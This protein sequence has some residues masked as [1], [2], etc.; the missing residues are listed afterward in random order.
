MVGRVMAAAALGVVAAVSVAYGEGVTVQPRFEEGRTLRYELRLEKERDLNM[1]AGEDRLVQEMGLSLETAGS[2]DAGVWTFEG[3]IEWVVI[4]VD[5]ESFRVRVDSRDIVGDSPNLAETTIRGMVE[6]YLES[7]FTA[8][9]SPE[10]EVLE[11]TGMAPVME[12]IG[13]QKGTLAPL[14][15]SDLTPEGLSAALAPVWAGDGSSGR[16]L[17]PGQTFELRR[18]NDLGAGVSI[19][20]TTAYEVTSAGDGRVAYEGTPGVEVVLPPVEMP[21]NIELTEVEG[22]ASVVWDSALGTLRTRDVSLAY[23]MT[24]SVKADESAPAQSSPRSFRSVLELVSVE[25]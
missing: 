15:S 14:A 3:S 23:T 2:D 9:V 1:G 16:T 17:A 8:R 20:V 18:E 5:R 13:E 25:D 12:F 4:D 22:A 11:I 10:G 6:K 21:I 24:L 7:T 19:A